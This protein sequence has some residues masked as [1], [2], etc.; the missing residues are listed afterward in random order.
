MELADGDYWIDDYG[1]WN[2]VALGDLCPFFANPGLRNSE[3]MDLAFRRLGMVRV[4]K[5]PGTVTVQWD[6][7]EACDESLDSACAFLWDVQGITRTKLRF[8]FGG[9]THETFDGIRDACMRF[10]GLRRYRHIA[11][12]LGTRIKPIGEDAVETTA[13][14]AV[15]R[16]RELLAKNGRVLDDGLLTR[17]A[18]LKL[19]DRIL[20]FQ[21]EDAGSWLSF[22]YIGQRSLFSRVFGSDVSTNLIGQHSSID[23]ATN[24]PGCTVSRAYPQ[25]LAVW[26]EQVDQVLVPIKQSNDD[27]IWV[28]YQRILFPCSARDGRRLLLV[29]ADPTEES[30]IAA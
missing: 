8:F 7:A 1:S 23:P 10:E 25:V 3:R 29:L 26:K 21:E 16:T 5:R 14:Q 12:F 27:R 28:S 17:L 11:P 18:E 24:Q 22:R 15:R 13:T 4:S 30:L 2:H 9:W 6:I 19:T 20:L